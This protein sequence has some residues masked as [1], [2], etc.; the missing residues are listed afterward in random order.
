MHGRT[1]N[2]DRHKASNW[3]HPVC[4][5]FTIVLHPRPSRRSEPYYKYGKTDHPDAQEYAAAK[6]KNYYQYL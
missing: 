3:S 6:G 5:S 4:L 1:V 2:S